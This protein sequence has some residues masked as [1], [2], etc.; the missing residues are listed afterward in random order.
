MDSNIRNK[1]KPMKRTLLT[2]ILSAI[3][4]SLNAQISYGGE[5]FSFKTQLSNNIDYRVMSEIDVEMLLAE[6]AEDEKYG[7]VAW[8]F[9]KDIEVDFDLSNSGTWETLESG[10]RIWRLEI[11]SYGALSINL[12]YDDF[13]MPEGG[14][15]FIYNPQKKHTI[16]SFTA[17]NNKPGGSFATVPVGG[18]TSILEYYEPFE[19]KG[20]GRIS[21][22]YVIHAYKNI[23]SFGGKGFGDSGDCN[24]NVNCPEGA[25]WN[26]QKRGVAMILNGN[27]N[28]ICTG[29]LI[30]NTAEDGIPYF[31]SARHCGAGVA[32]NWIVVFNYES[33]SCED[34]DGPTNQSIQNTIVRA[35]SFASDLLLLELSEQPPAEY[36]V[37]YN[38]WDRSDNIN[39]LSTA[40]HHPRGDIKK[41]S[42]DYDNTAP[43]TYLGGGGVQN[44]Y[45]RITQWDLGTTE[46]GSSGSPL[47]SSEKRIIGQLHGG[48]ASCTNL[49]PDW[50][51]K[52]SYSW[53]YFE[54]PEKQLK[55]WLDPLDTG[56]EVLDGL[57]G[58]GL[59]YENNAAIASLVEPVY[60][61]SGEAEVVPHLI[62]KNKGTNNLQSL[63]ISYQLDDGEIISKQWT[64]DIESND[65]AHVF[66]PEIQ[67]GFG[68]HNFLAYLDSPNGL[69]DEFPTNDS[70]R[71]EISV[72]YEY[73]IGI[74]KYASPQG[75]NCNLNPP[76]IQFQVINN[77]AKTIDGY[78]VYY[79]IDSEIG[80]TQNF[81]IPLEPA[82]EST[83]DIE[84]E[85]SDENWHS[86]FIEIGVLNQEDQ[87]PEDN[88]I[89]ADF[90]AYGNRITFSFFTDKKGEETS[91]VLKKQNGNVL[92]SG[93]GYESITQYN[94]DF[95]LEAD[96]Y[97][98]VIYDSG[99]DGISF[100]QGGSILLENST[101]DK[102]YMNDSIFSDSLLIPFCITNSLYVDFGA[103]NDTACINQSLSFFN[104]SVNAD[105]YEWTFEG[106][107]PNESTATNPSVVYQNTG[108]YDVKLKAWSGDTFVEEIKE[109]YITVLSCI[110]IEELKNN[111]FKIYPNPSMGK[112]TL[113]I[114]SRVYSGD[115][116]KA[117]NSLGMLVKDISLT[118]SVN[119]FEWNLPEGIYLLEIFTNKQSQT[120]VLLIKR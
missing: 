9:G 80:E 57:D 74:A 48:Y 66:M 51:G 28:R 118:E 55:I 69:Q 23:F 109:N 37:F 76:K 117:Y 83:V 90:N 8:R 52:F 93:S 75:I 63:N 39:T 89:S 17:K 108:V 115:R 107:I 42:F 68:N 81:E 49:E 22:S 79:A 3:V 62:F 15:F 16:G 33:P 106:G 114:T 67:L 91:W 87:V 25:E 103:E 98:F 100:P 70:I 95:C 105:A 72:E 40:I 120:G 26:D 29:S 2:L 96:C 99:G 27:N 60:S 82:A 97:E 58:Q 53:D 88:T 30:N 19:V 38:G 104:Q 59:V 36:D 31:L 92:F 20:E 111:I 77:G 5:P 86:I 41:I 112:F 7:D 102:V 12:I 47:F 78:S 46:G 10:D 65:T 43:D 56:Q 21:I 71:R 1:I 64:G 32:E 14:K 6:D 34:I 119:S 24:V 101:T 61:Y 84:L 54:E 73:D 13:F 113:E 45:W 50:Y 116:L 11:T 35:S 85:I 4:V 94:E 44:S 18:E 110:G